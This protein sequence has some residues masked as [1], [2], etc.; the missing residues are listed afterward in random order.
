MLNCII[1]NAAKRKVYP[2]HTL[3]PSR[4]TVISRAR[5][6]ELVRKTNIP[7]SVRMHRVG[8]VSHTNTQDKTDC[9]FTKLYWVQSNTDSLCF[10]FFVANKTPNHQYCQLRA[11]TLNIII[12]L[13]YFRF[14][15]HSPFGILT[16]KSRAIYKKIT[17]RQFI[18]FANSIASAFTVF[19][20][21]DADVI[22][23]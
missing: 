22:V 6:Y 7:L 20:D 2:L 21:S 16:H 10:E 4:E 12:F 3:T 18:I 8:R 5:L 23:S 17:C 19:N 14:G 9:S 1:V 13:R 15:E 11:A